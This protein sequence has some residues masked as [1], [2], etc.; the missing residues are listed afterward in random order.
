MVGMMT[1][2]LKKKTPMMETKY[3]A[4]LH[5]ENPSCHPGTPSSDG[6]R[7]TSQITIVLELVNE[8]E[9][10]LTESRTVLAV[11]LTFWVTYMPEKLKKA[12]LNMV[13]MN[14]V[15]RGPLFPN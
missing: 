2:L 12:M 9:S 7:N 14:Q 5:Q 11:A 15:S 10:Y 3:P 8:E 6:I 1:M 13:R 4:R